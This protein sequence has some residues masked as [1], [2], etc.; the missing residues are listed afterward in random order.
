MTDEI[1]TY[2]DRPV[3][4][5]GEAVLQQD[6]DAEER[7]RIRLKKYWEE[8]TG[9]EV[10]FHKFAKYDPIDF[11]VEEKGKMQALVEVKRRYIN[12]D[13]YPTAFLN[14]RKWW[15][16]T[17]IGV[18]ADV[19]PIYALE[20]NDATCFIDVNKVD[21]SRHKIGGLKQIKKSST[22]IE[23]LIEIPIGDFTRIEHEKRELVT[24]HAEDD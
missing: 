12:S 10:I 5:G 14:F 22:D 16:L 23:P 1:H 15:P 21:A 9:T 6:L 13:T 18:A 4:P 17:A 20:Y 3:G 19:V 2:E 7:V 24:F 11:W 8:A